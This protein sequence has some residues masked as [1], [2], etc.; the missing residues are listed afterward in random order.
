M[1]FTA[2]SNG[3]KGFGFKISTEV[4]DK[5]FSKN[6]HTVIIQLPQNGTLLNV[7]CNTNKAS[8]WNKT[9]REL[10]NSK[11]G[12]WLKDCKYYPWPEG[13]PPKFEVQKKNE[14]TFIILN[15]KN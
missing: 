11:I 3:D 13:M 5:Y 10:I 12:S 8:F 1:T 6:T 2:W 9:C 15:K 14:N 4:R 7:N